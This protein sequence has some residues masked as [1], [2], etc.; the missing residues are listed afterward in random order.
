MKLQWFSL[1]DKKPPQRKILLVYGPLG[2]DLAMNMAGQ[3]YFKQGEDWSVDNIEHWYFNLPFY[4]AE[5][6]LPMNKGMKQEQTVTE[7]ESDESF[8]KSEEI[9]F[10]YVISEMNA[11]A[12]TFKN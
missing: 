3:W 10:E 11:F 1:D 2:L 6:A 9:D 4:W 12:D 5:F 7:F 8:E